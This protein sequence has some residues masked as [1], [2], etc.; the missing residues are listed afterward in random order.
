MI[1]SFSSDNI[2]LVEKLWSGFPMK[3]AY[4]PPRYKLLWKWHILIALSVWLKDGWPLV[5]S[6]VIS[7]ALSFQ[8]GN[9]WSG[10]TVLTDNERKI[11]V[12]PD[13]V[14]TVEFLWFTYSPFLSLFFFS[15]LNTDFRN[16]LL[17]C[18]AYVARKHMLKFLKYFWSHSWD[19]LHRPISDSWNK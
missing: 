6:L 8:L 14:E 16:K 1:V 15:K 9:K 7:V 3:I 19:E 4:L 17:Q 12:R 18:C 2:I 5:V 13:N 10:D 11:S